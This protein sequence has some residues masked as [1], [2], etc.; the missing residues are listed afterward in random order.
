[1]AVTV[2]TWEGAELCSTAW[3][4]GGPPA[5]STD[6]GELDASTP[7]CQAGLVLRPPLPQECRWSPWPLCSVSG[8]GRPSAPLSF[9]DPVCLS[10]G[11]EVSSLCQ[12]GGLCVDRGPSYFCHCPPGFQGPTCQDRANPCQ[13]R[14]C[15]HGATCVAQPNGYLCQVSGSGCQGG[16]D[17]G[18]SRHGG[19]RDL[20]ISLTRTS[21]QP[22][23]QAILSP[24]Y[25]SVLSVSLHLR[26]L[27]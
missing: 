26:P 13:S 11:T 16:L 9:T 27:A 10:A 8:P 21:S 12:N 2:S 20:S 1:M 14:P 4:E 23:S 15:Q 24:K 25:F 5:S 7:L 19:G 6:S 17:M 18:D 22:P 3:G